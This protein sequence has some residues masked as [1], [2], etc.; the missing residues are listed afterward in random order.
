MKLAWLTDIH[1]NFLSA[2]QQTA[3]Y[4]KTS[5]IDYDAYLVTGDIA[6]AHT[7][8]NCLIEWVDICQRPIYFVLGNHDYYSSNFKTVHQLTRKLHEQ[9][10]LLNW[11][12]EMGVINLSNTHA[13]IGHGAWADG[14]YGNYL[15]SPLI[16]NDYIHIK[17]LRLPAIKMRLAKMREIA[18]ESAQ[19]FA[20]QLTQVPE[21]MTHITLA[22]HVPPYQETCFSPEG[23]V[24]PDDDFYLPHF[25][26]KA[27]GDVLR[28]YAQ[29]NPQRQLTVYC[30][31]T[32]GACD[33]EI[34]P[35]LRVIVG[36]A[37]YHKPAI[38]R[39]IEV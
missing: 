12:P 1:L 3:F 11:L 13:L 22:M 37:E 16:L 6:E 31:H 18:D 23:K 4:H 26:T 28:D 17:D 19:Y 2:E 8:A 9:Y 29:N 32:H 14:R 10:E 33:V 30:G 35:N 7:F 39:V 27:V 15:A 36:G 25:T 21:S 20:S 5:D 38:D 24:A 34:L